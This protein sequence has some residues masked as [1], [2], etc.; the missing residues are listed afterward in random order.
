MSLNLFENTKLDF[1]VSLIKLDR[2]HTGDEITD[3]VEVIIPVDQS[4]IL[5]L[6]INESS[7]AMGAKGTITISN[8]FNIFERLKISSNSPNDLYVAISIKDVEL[9]K[10]EINETDKVVT[11]VGLV[12]STTAG[13]KDIV[14]N[15]LIFSWEEAF[16]AATR[17]T[18]VEYFTGKGIELGIPPLNQVDVIQLAETFNTY[19]YKLA[20]TTDPVITDMEKSAVSNVKHDIK[21]TPGEALSVY[22]ALINMLKES[23]VG[24]GSEVGRVPYFRFINTLD[25][26]GTIKRK[27]RFDAFLTDKHIELI[28]VVLE[29]GDT[30][31]FSDVYIEKFSIGPLAETSP[32]DPNINL[33]NKI[34]TYNITR[35]DVGKLRETTWGDYQFSS[36]GN[37]DPGPFA[38]NGV[39]FADLE[40]A[41][42]ERD[43][44]G[45]KDVEV[46]LLLLDVKEI[47]V[48]QVE[49]SNTAAGAKL[50][51]ENMI[52]NTVIKSF[53]TINETISFT[54]KGSVIRQPNKFIWIERGVKEDDYKKLWYVNSVTHKF[55]DGKYIT[56]VIATK[57][58]GDTSIAAITTISKKQGGRIGGGPNDPSAGG[59]DGDRALQAPP[60]ATQGN[61]FGGNPLDDE[62]A[63]KD[64]LFL[65]Q[66]E[67]LN[68]PPTP[69]K[70]LT[71]IDSDKVVG[72]KPITPEQQ[73]QLEAWVTINTP[74][75]TAETKTVKPPLNKDQVSLLDAERIGVEANKRAP[76]EAS[77]EA[78]PSILD[79]IAAGIKKK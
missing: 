30:G 26:D 1:E 63:R 60:L 74:D 28:R 70:F 18:Q 31:D 6:E 45:L 23:T 20:S 13:S 50:Q 57:I 36:D 66:H 5:N 37:P 62:Q 54:I 40:L 76:K 16:V 43:L 19:I 79:T 35:A 59:G 46:N 4:A 25:L 49:V 33:Y 24:P 47:K 41:F 56:D 12:N 39:T 27:L 52:A 14:D 78:K 17:K 38:A 61:I 42:I 53:L 77:A 44:G 73:A 21:T 3:V 68:N 69:E 11:V 29:G 71:T 65:E 32:V 64:A 7:L 22:D 8:K 51:Q 48:F 34:E 9:T 75:D 67:A 10:T 55:K 58:F 15:I 2:S 72:K